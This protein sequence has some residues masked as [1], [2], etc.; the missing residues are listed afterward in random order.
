VTVIWN[1][2]AVLVLDITLTLALSQ[3]TGRGGNP[4]SPSTDDQP[5][6]T[7]KLSITSALPE[8]E[9]WCAIPVYNN[10]ATIVDVA[11]RAHAQLAH[12]LVIDD[13]STDADLR[14]LLKDVDVT[15]IRH[16]KNRGKGAALATAFDAAA[17]AGARYLV[18]LDGDGQHF[19]EDIPRF[20]PYLSDDAILIGSR[21][22]VVGDMPPSSTFGREFS[23]FWIG[24]ET[25]ALVHDTQSGFRVYPVKHMRELRI[26]SRHYN[27]EMEIITRAVWAGLCVESVP[28][29]VFYPDLDKRVSSFHPIRD[30]ARI[31]LIHTKLVLRELLPAPHRSIVKSSFGS[32][33][34]GEQ[35]REVSW[36]RGLFSPLG[37]AASVF[38]ASMFG[39]ILWPWGPIP[40]IFVAGRLH[41]NKA[42]ALFVIALTMLPVIP[43]I[44]LRIADRVVGPAAG[45]HWRWF[46]GSHIVAFAVAPALTLLVYFVAKLRM[47]PA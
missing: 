15:V 28:V 29:R 39:I 6:M 23:D 7:P 31:A 33:L 19:P 30:N 25:G 41:L 40:T 14:N 10:A 20:F 24:V 13:G 43:T 35:S 32:Q 22:E 37:L 16:P 21:D 4:K 8:T 18:T 1:S 42:A 11:R 12:V 17:Q 34:P 36:M 27:F 3:S 26:D 47:K 9:T 45:P 5:H 2:S 44:S 38:V 46:V